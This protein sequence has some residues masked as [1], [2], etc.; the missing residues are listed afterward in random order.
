MLEHLHS[1]QAAITNL[2]QSQRNRGELILTVP[3]CF[4]IHDRP[5]DYYRYTCYGLEFLFRNFKGMQIN[6]RNSWT[7]AINVLQV[8]LLMEKGN[9]S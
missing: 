9:C 5:Y 7:E 8:L 2:Y 4:P 1:P 3:F 6:E